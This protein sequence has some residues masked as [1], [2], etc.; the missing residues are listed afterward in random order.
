MGTIVGH[1][2]S[3]IYHLGI[4]SLISFV[5]PLQNHV[6]PEPEIMIQNIFKE[7]IQGVHGSV[8]ECIE[9][10]LPPAQQTNLFKNLSKRI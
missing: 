2:G 7:L 3:F 10:Y 8:S 6:L 9:V 5:T 4:V 1:R